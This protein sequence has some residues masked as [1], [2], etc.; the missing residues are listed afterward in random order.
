MSRGAI[1]WRPTASLQTLRQRAAALAT[2]RQF[3]ARRGLMEVETPHIVARPVT[4]PQLVN[5]P[6]RLAVQ[7]GI[8]SYLHTSPEFH[9]KRLLAAGTGDVYQICKVFRDGEIGPRHL[10]E[11]TLVEWYRR[12]V[13]LDDLVAETCELITAIGECVARRPPAPRR[14]SYRSIF[15]EMT[16]L[17]PLEAAVEE[18]RERI[19]ALLP[20][21]LDSGLARSLG[22][23]RESWLDLAMA[24]IIEPSLRDQGLVV[25]D[26]YPAMQSSLARL[27]PLAPG[28]A[29]RFEVYL[30]GLELANGCH[31][32]A[33]PAEQSQRLES[34]RAR[35]RQLGLPDV[36]ADAALLA[37]LESGL[38]DC[39]GVA[40]GFD[41]LLLAC[42]GLANITQVVSFPV[43]DRA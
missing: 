23:C 40:L 14:R 41:R 12:N 13:S 15:L 11:F 3:F 33:D 17:D 6:C 16:G 37:A 24:E 4:E 22:N 25:I 34:D 8:S 1:A 39:C 42:L 32:V 26:R 30:D 2:T 31:E 28:Y 36:A 38:P 27:D 9:M 7:A 35:R 19:C 5:V 10:P 43:P 21:R 20:G 18:F 29:E